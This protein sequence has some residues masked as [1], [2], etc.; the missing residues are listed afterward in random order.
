MST[1]AYSPVF[2]FTIK[3]SGG[4]IS[5]EKSRICGKGDNMKKVTMLLLIAVLAVG[6]V[7]A[8]G[9]KEDAGNGIAGKIAKGQN[10]SEAELIALAKEETGDFIAYGNSSRIKNAVSNFVKKYGAQIGL[11]EANALGT[12][13]NDTEIYTT[14]FQEAAGSNAKAASMVMIQD[15]AQLQVYRNN[16]QILE[17]YVPASIKGKVSDEDLVPLVHQYI[18]KLFIWNNLG[19]NAPAIKNVWELTEPSMKGRI[20]FKNPSTEQVNMNFLIMCTSPEWAAKLADAY[21]SYYGK[22]VVLGSYKNAGYKWVA[23]F[24]ANCNFSISSDTTICQTMAKADSA[25]NIGLFVLSK[26][27][28]VDASIKGNLTV[29]AFEASSVEPF[30]GFMY[31]LYAQIAANGPR[32][33][34]AMLFINYLM[35]EEGFTP[36]GGPTTSIM[37]AY[38]SSSDI[39]AS[40]GD[41]PITFW[42][43]CC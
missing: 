19:N 25:G 28:D 16:S 5:D 21:K 13:M 7:F 23:E 6:T 1:F 37:G 11:T 2:Y 33:Y 32:P 17:N 22:D 4:K 38:S 39:G 36:W 29:G 12:K 9:S 30:A 18:N 15:G 3:A 24:L 20:F 42:K 27:R 26:F 41:K 8:N 10:L 35:S 34:T 31:P 14:L 43:N 40:E